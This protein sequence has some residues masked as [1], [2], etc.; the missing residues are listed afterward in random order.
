MA[1]LGDRIEPGIRGGLGHC[2]SRR[3][4]ENRLEVTRQG[5]RAPYITTFGRL[6]LRMR[7]C[8]SARLFPGSLPVSTMEDVVLAKFDLRKC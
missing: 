1:G 8:R 4:A 2:G 3:P 6:M 5:R 7:G